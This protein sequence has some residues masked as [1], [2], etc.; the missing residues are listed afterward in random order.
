MKNE[1]K[2]AL[3]FG[4]SGNTG[5]HLVTQLLEKGIKVIAI[6]RS[7]HWINEDLRANASFEY[8]LLEV[9]NLDTDK[10]LTLINGVHYV[11]STLG[12]NISVKGIWGNPR[13][14]VTKTI[15]NICK[16]IIHLKP[17]MRVKLVLMAS[18]GCENKMLDEIQPL[19]QKVAVS[20]I[21]ALIPPHSDNETAVSTLVDKI[22]LNHQYIDWCIV[23]PDTLIDDDKV[24]H[25]DL[26]PSPT[27]NVIFNPGKT[28]RINVAN[29][30]SSLV[31]EDELW[32]KWRGKMPV[33]YNTKS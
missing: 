21:R 13:K 20:V 31:T 33:I 7:E 23:R 16:S 14:L 18:S 9:S 1:G 4:A 8:R 5:R 6:T 10:Y 12:H 15:S 27:R 22:G 28:S 24:N 29:V 25:Y 30:M 26:S 3:V 2:S 19:S 11:F 32:Q 17:E